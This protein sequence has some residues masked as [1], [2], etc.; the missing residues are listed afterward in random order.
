MK[1]NIKAQALVIVFVYVSVC[2][3]IGI[4][5][6][7]YAHSLHNLVVRNINHSKAYYAGEAALITGLSEMFY[8]GAVTTGAMSFPVDTG[9]SSLITV[10]LTSTDIGSGYRRIRATVSDWQKW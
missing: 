9:G 2:M 8:G 4:Y 5:M 6:M 10:G 3:L 1:K 7:Y